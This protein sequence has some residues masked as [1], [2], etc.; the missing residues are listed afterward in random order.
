MSLSN[1]LYDKI[2][3]N[4]CNHQILN[5]NNKTSNKLYFYCYNCNNIILIL[6]NKLYSTFKLLDDEDSNNKIEFDPIS[7]VKIMIQRQEEQIKDINEKIVLNY[8]YNDETDTNCIN[9]DFFTESEKFNH[10][11]ITN[12]EEAE[13][14]EKE[15]IKNIKEIG[16]Y[17]NTINK[18]N[19]KYSKL[20]FDENIFGK[21]KNQRNQILIYIHKL[22]TKLKY[23]DSTFYFTLYLADTY[24]SRIFSE[25]ISERDLFL[26]ILGFFL[27]SSKYI[28]DDIFEPELQIFCNIE[29]NITLSIE[30]IR[31]SEVQ[32]LT[33]INHNM[34]LYSPYDWI[35]IFL[36]NGI[37]FETEIK[38]IN[39]LGNIYLY[40]QKLLTLITS[41]L[42]FCKYTSM[43]IALSIIQL[44]REKFLNNQSEISDKLFKLLF[45]LY[46]IEFSDYEE[47]YN[48]IKKDL[49]ENINIDDE[50]E[51]SNLYS[52]ASSKCN[53]NKNIKSIEI[54]LNK[55]NKK[56]FNEEINMSN[57]NT[58]SREN[59]FKIFLNSNKEKKYIK[60]NFNIKLTNN[61]NNKNKYKFKLYSS[62]GQINFLNCKKKNKS[63]EKNLEFLPNNSIGI[64]KNNSK[65]KLS[66]NIKNH[67][68]NVLNTSFKISNYIPKEQQNFILDSFRNDKQLISNRKMKKSNNTL[69][70][71]YAPKFL[72]KTTGPNI[73]NINYIN[74]ININNEVINLYT[75]NDKKK[76][77][78]NIL[79]GL[80]LN[81]C[82]KIK[83]NN[84]NFSNN[85]NENNN[86]I[87]KKSSFTINNSNSNQINNEYN[88]NNINKNINNL[89][90]NNNFKKEFINDNINFQNNKDILSIKNNLFKNNKKKDLNKKDKYKTHILLDIQNNQNTKNIF[91]RNR[92]NEVIIPPEK[93]NKSCNKY[94][95]IGY[96]NINNNSKTK[97]NIK[98]HL[99]Q[100]K[101]IKIMNTNININVNNKINNRKFTINF[102][103]IVN[104]KI[105]KERTNNF[106]NKNNNSN[107]KRFKSL[108]SNKILLNYEK[109]KTNQK[110]NNAEHKSKNEKGYVNENKLEKSNFKILEN[111]I[112]IENDIININNIDAIHSR[113]PRL[114]FN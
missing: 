57:L 113:L 87:I 92:E 31:E 21:Y 22:C 76:M 14:L 10:S 64:F 70:I 88:I 78:K 13:N 5:N 103:D 15:K 42:Y 110:I 3:K 58:S 61:I 50:N 112:K 80:N 9:R 89:N 8:F 85:E 56:T 40:T 19:N 35:N 11:G 111:N 2:I 41:K 26:V 105:N 45:S 30:E 17:L 84:Q 91:N 53:I 104:Q 109:Y 34:F 46:G 62:P 63:T 101:D 36:S 24:L 28:E 72:I 44:S 93:E 54:K 67:K 77:N 102:K 74:N 37:L 6:N 100:K 29:K 49:S 66:P 81:L 86:Y 83:D 96:N 75:E 12:I 68:N 43:Q 90:I 52:N 108:N 60:T 106:I 59:K 71:N 99:G 82:Y 38:D 97:R 25:D 7:I 39:E 94:S 4:K 27:I 95:F 51:S 33:L 69:Y 48:I 1:S 114:K 32:C 55:N 107:K 20:I 23:N 16:N 73:N 98:I 18:K 47:C 79:S 65:K